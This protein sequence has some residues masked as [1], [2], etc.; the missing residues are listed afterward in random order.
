M[1]ILAT[2]VTGFLGSNF[3]ERIVTQDYTVAC[4]IRLD[5][6]LQRLRAYQDQIK[7]FTFESLD[8]EKQILDFNPEIII[9][10]STCYGRNG[11]S[12]S[13]IANANILYPLKIIEICRKGNLKTIINIDTLLSENL[14]AYSLSK[15]QLREWLKRLSTDSTVINVRLEQF[16]GPG[17]DVSKFITK[18]IQE[19]HDQKTEIKLTKGIQRRDFVYIEDLLEALIM[20]LNKSKNQ[21]NGFFNYEIGSGKPLKIR[22]VVEL[23][24]KLMQNKTTKLNFGAIAYRKNEKMKLKASLRAIKKLG[25]KP[26]TPIEAGLKYTIQ[27]KGEIK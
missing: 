24:S 25:W 23:I 3:L 15:F 6:K 18:I 12:D 9:H 16:Y 17:D 7:L 11:E 26:K 4:V 22:S 5:S 10:F 27:E 13:Y 1:R 21:K 8:F 20:I 2:G 14:N 19:I